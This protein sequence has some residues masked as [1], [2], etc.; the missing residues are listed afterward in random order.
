MLSKVRLP[1]L[2]DLPLPPM[3]NVTVTLTSESD[4]HLELPITPFKVRE[5]KPGR[6]FEVTIPDIYW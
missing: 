6:K 5:L 1:H 2:T 4:C 3:Q